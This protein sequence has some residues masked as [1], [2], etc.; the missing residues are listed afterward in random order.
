MCC[1]LPLL[2]LLLL[3]LLQARLSNRKFVDKAPEKVVAEVQ[4]QA[5][6]VAEQL[7]QI[8]EKVGKFQQL[9]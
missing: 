8:G 1:K 9:A 3:F 7:A 4:A 6:E 5:A 2:S